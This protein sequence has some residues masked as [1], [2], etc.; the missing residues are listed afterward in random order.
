[1]LD[2]TLNH[3]LIVQTDYLLPFAIT[4]THDNDD[5]RDLIQDTVCRALSNLDKF[6]EHSNMKAW[7]FTIMKNI[8][9]NKYRRKQKEQEIVLVSRRAADGQ[10]HSPF[11]SPQEG[12]V[13]G[14][15]I[16]ACIDRLPDF[17]KNPFLLHFEGYRYKE[18]AEKLEEPLGT[19]KSR[20]HFARKLLQ[21]MLPGYT[22]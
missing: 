4:L 19:I 14:K 7:M 3:Q 1:M 2:T 11:A 17:L 10:A 12:T 8:F 5:A 18:I 21:D 16:R 20:I 6:D 22:N 15:E 13:S 9:I